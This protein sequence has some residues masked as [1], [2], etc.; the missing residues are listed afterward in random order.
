MIVPTNQ[1]TG[2][3]SAAST[4]DDNDDASITS[5]GVNTCPEDG[6]FT[7]AANAASDLDGCYQDTGNTGVVSY[8]VSGMLT[9][10][11]IVVSSVKF[12]ATGDVSGLEIMKICV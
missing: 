10:S 9:S 1:A 8:T 3:T 11:G 5:G 12:E 2:T 6:S 4:D 7:I